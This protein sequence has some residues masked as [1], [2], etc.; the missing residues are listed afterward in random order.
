MN[1][2][3]VTRASSFSH[4]LTRV[5]AAVT[6]LL[7]FCFPRALL[8][9][10][11]VFVGVGVTLALLFFLVQQ[12]RADEKSVV[13][14]APGSI[15][16]VVTN[17][18]GV[19][20]A[21]IEIT[22]FQQSS[23]GPWQMVRIVQTDQSGAYRVGLLSAGIYR[24]LFNDPNGRLAQAYYPNAATIETATDIPV[25]GTNVDKINIT[26]P[27]GGRI[28]GT[29]TSTG[30]NMVGSITSA[31]GGTSGTYYAV[32]A[33]QK[34]G[35]Q[36]V[37]VRTVGLAPQQNN[38]SLAGLLAGVYR[39]CT[40]SASPPDSYIGFDP[41][42]ECYDNVYAINEA[43]DVSVKT[44]ETTPNI[45]FF[46]GDGSDM[47]QIS[48]QVTT[49]DGAAL[50]KISVTA[51][52]MTTN[53]IP[54]WF[55]VT[56]TNSVGVYQL[57][58]LL[59]GA[60]AVSFSDA[61]GAYV[62]ELYGDVSQIGEATPLTLTHREKR[63]N[64]DAKLTLAS[65]ITGTLLIK[66]E[67]IPQNGG[68]IIYHKVGTEWQPSYPYMATPLDPKTGQYQING[69][70]AGVY[71][72]AGYANVG[73]GYFGFYGGKT[74]E[75]ATLITLTVGETKPDANI[76]LT[77]ILNGVPYSGQISGTVTANGAP[78][79]GIKLS[80]YQTTCCL[81]PPQIPPNPVL[82]PVPTP[83]PDQTNEAIAS[84]ANGQVT[85]AA[86]S[87]VKPLVYVYTDAQGHYVIDGLQ[88][89]SYYLGVSDPNGLYATTYYNNHS[90]LPRAD[91]LTILNGRMLPPN[92]LPPSTINLALAR[93]GGISGNVQLKDGT[94][95]ANV[96]V[97]A[98]LYSEQFRWEL[99]TVD[100]LT[101]AAGH[102]TIKGLP[103]GNYRL[104]FLDLTGK[105]PLECDGAV[106]NFPTDNGNGVAVKAG[107]INTINHLL[108][109]TLKF[110]LPLVARETFCTEISQIS[111]VECA[112]LL[113]IYKNTNPPNS[114]SPL[115]GWFKD[116]QPCQW[117]G[118]T[119]AAD[120]VV[121]LNLDG[122][123]L[124][125]IPV[126]I[127]NLANLESL[128]LS[129]NPLTTIPDEI[130]NLAN[131]Q[132]LALSNIGMGAVPKT[133]GRLHNLQWLDLSVNPVT[134]IAPELGDLTNLELLALSQAQLNTFPPFIIRLANL[135][136]LYL[137][138]DQLTAIPPE[139]SQLQQLQALDLSGNQ[140]TTLPKTL[141]NV[142]SLRSLIL[143]FNQLTTLPT[144]LGK[145]R[146]LQK[147]NVSNNQLTMIPVEFGNLNNL[148]VLYL[149]F[150]PQLS[151]AL[152]S[153]FTKLHLN[154]FWFSGTNLC[155]PTAS[156]FQ[157]WLNQIPD[158]LRSGV[159]CAPAS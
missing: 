147:L 76:V 111:R 19:P 90:F 59:P 73:Y 75:E 64:I 60:Y 143:A 141:G 105:Y 159:H 92:G 135:R 26:L 68:L 30:T 11:A 36:W 94:P 42:Q 125:T 23:Y 115:F 138:Q 85:S 112:A 13:P 74:V 10:L 25:A 62:S 101:D 44:G 18:A 140:L 152:P 29:I 34:V 82:T 66:D 31:G 6:C 108:G 63:T 83:A 9:K 81:Y 78:V 136:E 131:L 137:P 15:A 54:N 134:S 97:E 14:D 69:L 114:T 109:P 22:A 128:T 33:F 79:A 124:L 148:Q 139:L 32:R 87:D 127:G 39:V 156:A 126:Q 4:K 43:N 102:Y 150:N 28:T 117:F 110:F 46:L 51:A 58:N 122:A 158:L 56:E 12:V 98:F 113:Q 27:L 146:N 93:G 144:T 1:V 61:S 107:I 16:G 70:P 37:N 7:A 89:G 21:G 86:T 47:A 35:V 119:C 67:G 129:R 133:L 120:H 2:T 130:G 118:I 99:L 84:Q 132:R 40:S 3:G 20:L 17:E 38:Y 142:I 96:V 5:G 77:Q 104:C 155:E 50:P 65:H 80:L 45:N 149:H 151:G 55:Q 71:K 72:M 100:S 121:S 153:S 157:A 52:R 8:H 24:L 103:E 57:R 154:S 48:G 49:S 145:L 123:G 106:D 95:V 88:D 116:N 41:F 53:S 91:S